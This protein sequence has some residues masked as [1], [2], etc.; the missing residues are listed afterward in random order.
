MVIEYIQIRK[1]TQLHLKF[2]V[3]EPI[4]IYVTCV[5]TSKHMAGE[6]LNTVRA[7]L[8]NRPLILTLTEVPLLLR[9]VPLASFVSV[10]SAL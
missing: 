2:I 10:G 8:K 6:S 1:P 7:M 3:D 9:D 5:P 4:S